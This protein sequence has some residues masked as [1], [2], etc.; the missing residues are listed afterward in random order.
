MTK[1]RIAKEPRR[2]WTDQEREIL[3]AAVRMAKERV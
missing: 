1:R 3:R 2:F